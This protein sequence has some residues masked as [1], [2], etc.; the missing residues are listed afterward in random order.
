MLHPALRNM[1]DEGLAVTV[2]LLAY[3]G[4]LALLAMLV[5]N[6]FAAVP[7]DESV[8][9]RT[10]DRWAAATR[11][12]PAFDLPVSDLLGKTGAYEIYRHPDGG[13]KDIMRW[14]AAD[15]DAPVAQLEIYRPGAELVAFASPA[16]ELASRAA[17]ADATGLQ[18]AGLLDSKF[19]LI[20]LLT[21]S[22][23]AGGGP[24]RCV[25]FAKAFETP[26]MQISGWFCQSETAVEQRALAACALNRLTM[27]SAG[28]D[29][30]LAE[31][32]AHAELK[33]G[34]CSVT[35][36]TAAAADWLTASDEPQLRGLAPN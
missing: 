27:L 12:T 23:R 24:G 5:A 33:R 3:L 22:S 29:P 9:L 17:P 6:L 14:L 7:F 16:T 26:R 1:A 19:G 4:G 21:F 30:R 18:P 34:A 15:G 10:R 28:N 13:R 25:G 32:F 36:S 11:P 2:R 31:M 35:A 8:A 20:P